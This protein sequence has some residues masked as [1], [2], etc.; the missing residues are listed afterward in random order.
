MRNVFKLGRRLGPA[1][2][3][4]ARDHSVD[5]SKVRKCLITFK[6]IGILRSH[7]GEAAL[8]ALIFQKHTRSTSSTTS[9]NSLPANINAV[10]RDIAGWSTAIKVYHRGSFRPQQ[11]P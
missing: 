6:T 1:L 8:A 7:V 11:R 10:V 9:L 5:Q 3:F 4:T 2:R